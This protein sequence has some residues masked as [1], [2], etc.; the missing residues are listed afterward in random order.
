MSSTR[1]EWIVMAADATDEASDPRSLLEMMWWRDVLNVVADEASPPVLEFYG[2]VN[3]A[4][5]ENGVQGPEQLPP[6]VRAPLE[7]EA[8][9]ALR[10]RE[11]LALF[12]FE[13]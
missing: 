1:N 12:G 10:V 9:L 7:A 3:D 4:V 2:R 8:H 5:R 6:D 11:A 13:L